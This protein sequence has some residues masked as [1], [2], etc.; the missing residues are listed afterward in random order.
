[1]SSASSPGHVLLLSIPGLRQEDLSRMPTLQSLAAGG[2]CVPLAPGF[3]AVT[4]PVQATLTTGC[5]G[6]PAGAA[7]VSAEAPAISY[8]F[9]PEKFSPPIVMASP[10]VTTL[11]PPTAPVK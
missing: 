9:Q 3:P 11:L 1:M 2:D 7:K 5:T 6:A 10:N 4:C 8:E